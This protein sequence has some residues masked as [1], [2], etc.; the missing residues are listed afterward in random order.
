[1]KYFVNFFGNTLFIDMYDENGDFVTTYRKQVLPEGDT[2]KMKV[3]E[4][5][6]YIAYLKELGEF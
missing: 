2:A 5:F 6:K 4:T 1:M 3:I